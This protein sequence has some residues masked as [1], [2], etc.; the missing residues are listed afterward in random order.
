MKRNPGYV[1][2]ANDKEDQ[3]RKAQDRSENR[4]QI[5]VDLESAQKTADRTTL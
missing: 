1:D 4:D 3:R 5:I 2:R